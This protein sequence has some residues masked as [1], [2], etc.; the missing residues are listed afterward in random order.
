MHLRAWIAAGAVALFVLLAPAAAHAD[1]TLL[2][3]K[4]QARAGDEV[5]FQISGTRAGESYIVKVGDREVASGI[6]SAGNGVTDKFRMPDFGGSNQSVSVEVRITVAGDADHLGSYPGGMQYVGASSGGSTPQPAPQPA[7]TVTVPIAEPDPGPGTSTTPRQRRPRRDPVANPRGRKD[8]SPTDKPK[9]EPSGGSPPPSTPTD[10]GSGATSTGSG[11]ATSTS[12]DS[13]P[14]TVNRGPEVP[15]PSGPSGPT[16]GSSPIA[17]VLAPLSGL[18]QPGKTGFPFLLI[19]LFVLIAATVLTAVGP[20]LWRRWEPALPWG[21]EVDDE[22]RLG[23]LSRAS[24]SGAE[25]QQTIAARRAT[26]SAG[27]T[28]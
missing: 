27:R 22:V 14:V 5:E 20:R 28:G 12:S 16:G 15:G 13:P 26:R 17:S 11:G 9:N 18:A 8:P 6:D 4:S 7:P 21:P 3:S 19:L 23:A 25:L 2:V 10:T 24:K 1:H